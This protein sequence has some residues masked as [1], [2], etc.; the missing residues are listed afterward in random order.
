MK[1]E[2]RA[3]AYSATL[4][5][6]TAAFTA[7]VYIDGQ[8]AGAAEN[9]GHGGSTFIHPRQLEER[10][11]AHA[12]TLPPQA[13]SLG[14]GETFESQ[15]SAESLIDDALAAWLIDRDL[16]R[17]LARTVA[18]TKTS[19]PG[20]FTLKLP[21][22]MKPAA[23]LATC[24]GQLPAKFEADKVLNVLPFDEARTVFAGIAD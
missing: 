23:Y 2:L 20:L 18:F 12:R 14:N 15:P 17:L 22:G 6:E 13:L 19:K 7:A 21:K 16:K 3:V 11:A 8:K 1:I 24:N 9:D 5:Q 10:L 4:S